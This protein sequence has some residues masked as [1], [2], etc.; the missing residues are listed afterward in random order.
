MMEKVDF[1]IG[2][3]DDYQVWIDKTKE[4][5]APIHD[6]EQFRN[7]N[8]VFFDFLSGTEFL[9]SSEGKR[10]HLL[11]LD[12]Q[13]PEMNG[14]DVAR[15]VEKRGVKTKIIFMSELRD[16]ERVAMEATTI[17]SVV[18]FFKKSDQDTSI[19]HQVTKGVEKA[20]DV[21]YIEIN[22]FTWDQ[23]EK[24]WW[25]K[26][27]DA[28]KIVIIESVDK[29]SAIYMENKERFMINKLLKVVLNQLSFRNFVRV[30]KSKAVN[31]KYVEKVDKNTISIMNYSAITIGRTYKANFLEARRIF[32]LRRL[33]D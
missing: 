10:C 27:I 21:S 9:E 19:V 29:E 24:V 31:L 11:L 15:E 18:D 5:L 28:Q 30:S 14:L 32:R 16:L 13:M 22:Y 2:I 1:Y 6:F 26:I 4:K 23:G 33:E 3:V 25:N 17:G 7:I 20:L 8:F 12:Y